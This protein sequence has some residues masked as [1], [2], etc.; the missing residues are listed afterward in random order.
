MSEWIAIKEQVPG[1]E[2]DHNEDGAPLFW[3]T[4]G[5]HCAAC[6]FVHELGLFGAN[7]RV[8]VHA[9]HWWSEPLPHAP[10]QE[11]HTP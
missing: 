5:K 1:P 7:Q 6:W 3:V 11:E 10:K 4:D 2:H 8:Y 9:T